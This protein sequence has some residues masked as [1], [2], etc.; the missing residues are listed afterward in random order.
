MNLRM[1]HK[2][3]A[4][5]GN[6]RFKKGHP[7]EAIKKLQDKYPVPG[8]C[9][10]IT[11]PKINPEVWAKLRQPKMP[12]T[13]YPLTGHIRSYSNSSGKENYTNVCPKVHKM[14]QICICSLKEEGMDLLATLMTHS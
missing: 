6:K 7:I 1:K 9:P 5:M 12:T 10:H 14:S 8:N 3:V 2:K 11:V 13:V 4:E